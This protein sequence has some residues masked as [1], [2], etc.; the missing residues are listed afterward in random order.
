[1][2]TEGDTIIEAY[3][4]PRDARWA[5][6]PGSCGSPGSG[7]ARPPLLA[8]GCP[9]RESPKDTNAGR[10]GRRASFALRPALPQLHDGSRKM[11]SGL[12][13]G[14]PTPRPL[15]CVDLVAEV[16]SDISTS[17]CQ[18]ASPNRLTPPVPS[19]ARSSRACPPSVVSSSSPS[20]APRRESIRREGQPGTPRGGPPGGVRCPPCRPAGLCE[21]RPPYR[22]SPRSVPCP[23][24]RSDSAPEPGFP[25]VLRGRE[26]AGNDRSPPPEGDGL[27]G[28]PGGRGGRSSRP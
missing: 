2:R 25:G 9:P 8:E 6:R 12:R 10:G 1:M 20:S 4:S 17:F 27:R 26:G 5:T 11:R 7:R 24:A 13:D 15:V 19:R 22:E 18:L 21:G 16:V 14:F 23:P 3:R 28:G